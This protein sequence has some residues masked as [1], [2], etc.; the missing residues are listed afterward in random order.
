MYVGDAAFQNVQ[1]F[2]KN[3]RLL[4]FFGQTEGRADGLNLPAGITIDYDHVASFRRFAEPK[5]NIEYLI[6]V[7]SQ[8]GPNKVDI[9]GFGK[10]DGMDYPPDAKLAAKPVS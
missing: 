2:D 10:M 1:I 8:F 4:L 7:A 9:F 3:G 5:F 6:L